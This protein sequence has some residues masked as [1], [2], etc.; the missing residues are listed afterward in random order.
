MMA[1]QKYLNLKVCFKHNSNQPYLIKTNTD[2]Y[3]PTNGFIEIP[4]TLTK[5]DQEFIFHIQGLT[6]QH[7]QI[8]NSYVLFDD[9]VLDITVQGSFEDAG[10]TIKQTSKIASDGRFKILF[11]KAWIERN[12][13]NDM[14]L[15]PTTDFFYNG[16]SDYSNKDVLRKNPL[17][18][19]DIICVG[20]SITEGRGLAR[21]ESWPGHLQK[22][23]NKTIGSFSYGGICQHT[24]IENALYC[25][26]HY[27]FKNLIMLLP[28]NYFLPIKIK[29]LDHHTLFT[30]TAHERPLPFF[31]RRDK[32]KKSMK[33]QILYKDTIDKLIQKKLKILHDICLKQGINFHIILQHDKNIYK[34]L[35]VLPI[36]YPNF[37]LGPTLPDGHP[38][39]YHNKLFAENLLPYINRQ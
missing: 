5:V 19:Y 28:P 2:E 38:T 39:F 9:K 14:I 23:L 33:K 15:Y 17:E 21:E 8:I 30:I 36:N 34:D 37:D 35:P 4:I 26:R 22:L 27:N 32:I 12:F 16:E 25:I 20:A 29:F 31:I 10:N 13:L 3:F 7:G 24:I 11:N 1:R 18:N 6:G